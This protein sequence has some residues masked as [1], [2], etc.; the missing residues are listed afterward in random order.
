MNGYQDF[1]TTES[2]S[3]LITWYGWVSRLPSKSVVSVVLVYVIFI[4]PKSFRIACSCLSVTG[5]DFRSSVI[6]ASASDCHVPIS[7]D[8]PR[9]DLLKCQAI[10]VKTMTTRTT[11]AA[12]A[13]ITTLFRLRRGI[14]RRPFGRSGSPLRDLGSIWLMASVIRATD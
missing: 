10:Q 6:V 3:L 1:I 12:E 8:S 11:P 2:R 14:F 7:R 9:P 4:R 13:A 5:R